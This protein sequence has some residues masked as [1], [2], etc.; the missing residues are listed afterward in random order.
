MIRL[1]SL[2]YIFSFELWAR[3]RI[4]SSIY[5]QPV[6][7]PSFVPVFRM[8]RKGRQRRGDKTASVEI[9][10]GHLEWPRLRFAAESLASSFLL[11][12][13]AGKVDLIFLPI[14]KSTFSTLVPSVLFRVLGAAWTLSS[15]L[16]VF[17]STAA[18]LRLRFRVWSVSFSSPLV[19]VSSTTGC[20][21]ATEFSS[22]LSQRQRVFP[23]PE[24][25]LL[26]GD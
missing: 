5:S 1:Y 2:L 10:P 16:G 21:T 12:P 13:A 23:S 4:S 19:V 9:F 6:N 14:K 25:D 17:A 26:I 3:L 22:T 8:R 7:R 18:I 20:W 15:I 24:Q 11:A